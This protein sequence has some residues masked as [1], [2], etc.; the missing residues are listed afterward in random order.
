MFG[1]AGLQK[2]RVARR[3]GIGDVERDQRSQ[4]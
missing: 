1:V 4:V 3:L 2:R